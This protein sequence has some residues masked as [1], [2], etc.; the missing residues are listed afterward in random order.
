MSYDENR[1]SDQIDGGLY[2]QEEMS[3]QTAV[4]YLFNSLSADDA[5]KYQLEYDKAKE[6]EKSQIIDCGMWHLRDA[7][8]LCGDW[9]EILDE[10]TEYYDKKFVK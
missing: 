1:I 6:I 2:K 8:R 10:A 5:F 3:K 7:E 9:Y 4:D